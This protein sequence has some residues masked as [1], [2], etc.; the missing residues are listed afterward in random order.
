MFGP[1]PPSKTRAVAVY[2][3]GTRFTIRKRRG[4]Y[5]FSQGG[6]SNTMQGVREAVEAEGGRIEREPNPAYAEHL[7]RFPLCR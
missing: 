5:W 1:K 4:H 2:A 6:G 7:R 3:D